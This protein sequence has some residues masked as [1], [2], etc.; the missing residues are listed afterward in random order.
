MSQPGTYGFKQMPTQ[1]RGLE[2]QQGVG[3][4]CHSSVCSPWADLLQEGDW[5]S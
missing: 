5:Q 1:M 2:G 4:E 3:K